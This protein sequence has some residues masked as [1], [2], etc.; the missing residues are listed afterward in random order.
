M[1]E[2][3]DLM[4]ISC[5]GGFTALEREGFLVLLLKRCISLFRNPR[6]IPSDLRLQ[7]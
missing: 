2:I 7:A 1:E 5:S 4:L 6:S 3:T